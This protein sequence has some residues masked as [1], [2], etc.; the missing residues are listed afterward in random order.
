MFIVHQR[1]IAEPAN[2][3]L[4]DKHQKQ[5]TLAKS[6]AR[7][8]PSDLTDY[9]ALGDDFEPSRFNRRLCLHLITK[10]EEK[11]WRELFEACVPLLKTQNEVLEILLPYVMYY[12][13]RFNHSDANLPV[14]L[15]AAINRILSSEYYS[16]IAP[17]LK[18]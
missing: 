16:Q 4:K 18:A 2:E 14:T 7:Y 13:M 17:I 12:A 1:L 10:I 11:S 3:A 9:T 8:A 6:I 5:S 15:A